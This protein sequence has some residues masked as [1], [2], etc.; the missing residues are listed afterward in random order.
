ME[1][2]LLMP[3]SPSKTRRPTRRTA[4]SLAAT[5][6]L[7]LATGCASLPMPADMASIAPA[8]SGAHAG[9]GETASEPLAWPAR[10]AAPE[11]PAAEA[12][13]ATAV[14]ISAPG[15]AVESPIDGP[16]APPPAP[17]SRAQLDPQPDAERGDLWAR[18]RSGF[19]MPDADGD[20][21][22]KW[23]HFYA[24][25]PDYMQRMLARGSLYLFHVMEEIDK[26]QMPAE[27]ALLPFI[28]SAFN[29]QAQSRAKASGMWQFMPATGKDFDLRQN[30]FRDDRR[31]VLA[32]TRAALDYLQR[33]HGMFGDWHLALA[34]YNWGQ[35]NVLRAQERSRR[36]RL[37]TDYA[38]LRMPDETRNYVP[39]LQAMKNLISRPE[40]FALDLPRLDN[41]PYFLSV[42]IERDIDVA[43]AASLAG[44]TLDEFQQLNPQLN[45]PVILAAGTPQVLLPYDNA[46]QFLRSLPL[47]QTPLASFTAWVAPRTLKV[48]DAA[49]L[50]GT[51]EALLRQL[52]SIPA[53]MMVR[54][55][56]TLLV[57]R[58]ALHGSDVAEHIADHGTML[59][60]PE[61]RQRQ[62]AFKAGKH[63]DTVAAVA[64]R[65][66]VSRSQVADW[67]NVTEQSRFKPGQTITVIV[68]ARAPGQHA[69]AARPAQRT[70]KA[71]PHTA[72]AGKSGKAPTVNTAMA[73]R[74]TRTA[75]PAAKATAKLRVAQR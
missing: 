65:Y 1:K 16:T 59:L 64:Q 36:G 57:P 27:L 72:N 40:A 18:V 41:H 29:P 45:K 43:L 46:N 19:A 35:G 38:S 21:V 61:S 25:Q 14:P 51:N 47:V 39:K 9:A 75:K 33:L 2:P 49:R 70:G 37:G 68:A 48:A 44:L 12:P 7:L 62:L 67:N 24:G 10:A 60:T 55:G 34:A 54:T 52:N 71:T 8:A 58:S 32:S 74:A 26:R 42:A 20:L 4:S 69:Q 11:A 50:A 23:E 6:A 53:R 28:E 15:A 73:K 22:R 56:A 17:P 3:S 31:D 66:R 30:L 13:A 63:G 5:L